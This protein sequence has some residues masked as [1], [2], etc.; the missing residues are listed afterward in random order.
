M[1]DIEIYRPQT[2]SELYSHLDEELQMRL[3]A[4][5]RVGYGLKIP[6]L[7]VVP[8]VPRISGVEAVDIAA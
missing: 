8:N 5:E 4:A 6:T 1:L 7:A 2:M 3:D